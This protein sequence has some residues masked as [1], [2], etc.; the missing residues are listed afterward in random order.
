MANIIKIKTQKR[1]KRLVEKG[2]SFEVR[3]LREHNFFVVD[4]EFLDNNWMKFLKGAPAVVY[5]AICRH[6]DKQQV[7]FP[8]IPY[9]VKETG[10]GKRQIIRAIKLL[11]FHQLISVSRQKGNHNMYSLINRKHW[12]KIK[13]AGYGSSKITPTEQAIALMKGE[14]GC[15]GYPEGTL[16]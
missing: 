5:F 13:F 6:S 16:P 1:R 11:E 10:Y 4:N 9:L 14:P 12:K 7:S 15:E 8:S 3:D 2:G